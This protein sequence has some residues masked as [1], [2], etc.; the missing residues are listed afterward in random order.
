MRQNQQKLKNQHGGN[1]P[2]PKSQHK[3][4]IS[5][6][7]KSFQDEIKSIFHHF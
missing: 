6:E 1:W 3:N 4:L 2:L 5:L 7:Q